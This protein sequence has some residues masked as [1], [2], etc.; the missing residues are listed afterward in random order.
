MKW[1]KY[2]A[3]IFLMFSARADL[4]AQACTTL[5]QTPSTAFPVCGTSVFQQKDVP[6]CGGTKIT[7]PC[8][9]GTG[10]VLNDKNPFWYKFTCYTAG[11][12][13]FTITPA[14]LSDDYDWQLWDIT[15]KDPNEVFTNGNLF[16]ACNWSGKT[17]V[18][19]AS[20][21]GTAAAICG[22]QVNPGI[23]PLFTAM[24]TLQKDHQY[25][26]MISH[27][28]GATQSGYQ[29]KFEGGTANITD[30][31]DPAL[32][33]VASG[34]DAMTIRVKLN[35]TMKCNSIAADGS[36]F[37]ITGNPKIISAIGNNC[38]TSF[39]MDEVTLTLQDPLPPGKYTVTVKKGT[40]GN[41]LKD[42]CDREVPENQSLDV[43]ILPLIPMAMDSI[44]P[45]KCEP[46]VINVV[47]RRLIIMNTAD[48]SD[49]NLVGPEARSIVGIKGVNVTNGMSY[50]VQLYLNAPIQTGGVWNVVLKKGI[51]GNTLIDECGTEVIAG[52]KNFVA[53]DTVNANFNTAITS[54]CTVNTVS[55]SHNGAHNVSEWKWTFHDN[56]NAFTQ[57]VTKNYTEFS[58]KQVGLIVSNG[59][60]NDSA[61]ATLIF[62][63]ELKA[64]FTISTDS[65][66]PGEA[67]T[68]TNTTIGNVV[69][70]QWNFND[71]TT[72]SA[73]TP[74]DHIFPA[75]PKT[76]DYIIQLSA[77]NNYGCTDIASLSVKA[78][79]SCFVA[80]PSAFTPNG[81]GL[82]DYLYPLNGFKAS[83]LSFK[84]FNRYGQMVFETTDWNKRW[85][86]K[87]NGQMQPSGTYVWTFDYTDAQTQKQ[88]SY[89]GT[90][91]LIR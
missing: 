77:T 64:S 5:G 1:Y 7:A 15:G 57:T 9:M 45:V 72:S 91:V 83:K 3:I 39:D 14:N 60:C 16:V 42:N 58:P 17:G 21:S 32:K 37:T 76:R 86:G 63:N 48:V 61:S 85:D 4:F 41:T 51:D 40:D 71:G 27:F 18:T 90:T 55:F 54:S 31:T 59:V 53:Y 19:G 33:S 43:E 30:P 20:A 65:L 52:S 25:I 87:I 62:D 2:L 69:N 56:T 50:T 66:C 23:L 73:K 13:G 75:P 22:D 10:A 84:V 6:I 8:T 78:L 67:V 82:N 88:Y 34:C 79:Q 11:T 46:D 70:W 36:D 49:F 68:L 47:F 26:L 28:D 12:L 81:D 89:R 29:L 44:T 24:P 38:S 74:P 80:I 35:K